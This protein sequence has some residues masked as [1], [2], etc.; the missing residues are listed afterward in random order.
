MPKRRLLTVLF[1]A[2]VFMLVFFVGDAKASRNRVFVIDPKQEAAEYVNL[3]GSGNASGVLSVALG[4]IEDSEGMNVKEYLRAVRS[5]S[6]GSGRIDFLIRDPDGVIVQ[7]FLNVSTTPFSFTANKTG[8]YSLCMENFGASN[9][10]V[11]LNYGIELEFFGTA[12]LNVSTSASMPQIIPPTIFHQP[13][14]DGEDDDG[15]SYLVKPYLNFQGAT[16]T[17]EMIESAI[18][19]LPV[20]VLDL[21]NCTTIAL[22]L[23][24]VGIAVGL[25]RQQSQGKKILPK[26]KLCPVSQV[27]NSDAPFSHPSM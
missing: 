17:L 2:T 10:T 12:T 25:L 26:L 22:A 1:T 20:R 8:N 23:A 11:E 4:P 3:W 6:V 5:L 15:E 18:S 7:E 24:I 19:F 9:V 21:E 16:P 27:A 13:P 14:S